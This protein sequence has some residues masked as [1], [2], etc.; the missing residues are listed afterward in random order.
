MYGRAREHVSWAWAPHSQALPEI[1]GSED[2]YSGS[3]SPANADGWQQASDV[4]ETVASSISVA[5]CVPTG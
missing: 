4:C 3:R 5:S 2:F 1:M